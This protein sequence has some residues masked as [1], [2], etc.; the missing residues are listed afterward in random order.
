MVH[1]RANTIDADLGIRG[2]AIP[3]APVQPLDLGHDHRL[4]RRPLRVVI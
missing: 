3:N 2:F 4:R 1:D